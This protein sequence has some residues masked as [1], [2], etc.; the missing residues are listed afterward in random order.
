MSRDGLTEQNQTTGGTERISRREQDADFQKTPE[1]QAAQDAA[2][3]LNPLSSGTSPPHVPGL[4]PKPDTGTAEQVFEHIDG[5]HTRK[6]AKKAAQKAQQ[7]ATARTKSS[8][9]Q[10][11]DEERANPELETYIRKSD[12]AADRLDA[13]KA[14]V[15]KK[16]T[17]A[18]E[19]TFDEATGKGKTRLHFEE[20]E[21]PMPG[22]P[23]KNPL[24]RPAQEAGIFVH[25]KIHSVEKDNSGVE[26]AHKSEEAAERLG[27]Y[28]T[29]KVKQGYRSHK[30]KPYRAAAKA[31]KAAAKANV[32]FQYHKTL[33]DN[34]QLASNPVSRLWQKQQIKRQY[35]KAA[36]AGGAKGIRGAAENVR[37]AA[38]KTAEKTRQTAA[39]VARHPAG[40]I[41]AIAALL[42]FIMVFAGLSSCSSMFSG[43][44]NGVLGTSYTSEDS[45]L[46]AVENDY[47]SKE[48]ELQSRID[49]IERDYP[50]YDEYRYDLAAIGHNPHELASYLTA[51]LQTYTPES[52]QAELNRVFDKQYTLTITETVEIR[53]RT[54]TSTDEDGNTT[55]EEVPYEYYILNVKLTNT[56]ISSLA[57]ELL[58]PEQLEMFRVYLET[59]GNK[60]L[61]FGGGSPDGTPSEDLS[62]VDF[63]NG[64]RPGNTAVVDIA[65]AQVG[66]VGGYPYWSWY[67]FNS[68]VEWCACFVSWCYNQMGKSEP[69]FAACQ[70]QGIPWF[71]SHGQWGDRSYPNIAPGD[72]IFFDWDLDGSADHVGIVIG[73][74]GSRVYTVEGNSGDACK[75]KSY[76]LDYACIKGYG[77][78]NW[79]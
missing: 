13:A 17:L 1:Q 35:A 11:T 3:Q 38:K 46:V 34:P 76:S 41:I 65:K 52:A 18:A 23:T 73:T 2:A 31:E 66:N 33:A 50:G 20:K 32:N 51:L 70:S 59:S 61:I 62:G 77:L 56:P 68:R 15:P 64:T 67:G 58:T 55:T 74:D 45:D 47:V 19:R 36:R 72:A 28:T 29:R 39:F 71:Q 27:K 7:E 21:K 43:T 48:N 25:N 69:R 42:L 8:R 78:M 9:L 60:P 14:A 6:A 40:V 26:G 37:R 53:Y 75:V 44:L 30:L 22:K 5:R 10:F 49:N 57:P 4:A 24:S 79:N 12:K 54:E 63:V 16:K